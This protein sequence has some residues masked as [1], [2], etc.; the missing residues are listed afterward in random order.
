MFIR[1]VSSSQFTYPKSFSRNQ[2]VSVRAEDTFLYCQCT[3]TIYVNCCTISSDCL[4]FVK[5]YGELG[6]PKRCWIVPLF[7]NIL[8]CV[9][10]A[11]I[12]ASMLNVLMPCLGKAS[13]TNY[14][15]VLSAIKVTYTM[16]ASLILQERFLVQ[17]V[18]V[19]GLVYRNNLTW[20]WNELLYTSK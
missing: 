20:K 15:L 14:W 3:R 17:M 12:I 1:W 5:Y 11:F 2:Q 19:R 9:V 4:L 10:P 6:R 8:S 7:A 18:E 16:I 13:P